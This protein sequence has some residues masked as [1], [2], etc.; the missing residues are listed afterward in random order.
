MS[1][2][3]WAHT[4]TTTITYKTYLTSSPILMEKNTNSYIPHLFEESRNPCLCQ[5]VASILHA[6][7]FLLISFF[8]FL[9]Y[10]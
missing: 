4:T 1:V 5:S 2:C 10:F 6:H 8:F 9:P 3:A 7:R